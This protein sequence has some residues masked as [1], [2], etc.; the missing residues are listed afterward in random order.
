[1]ITNFAGK[2][3]TNWY[4]VN[5]YIYLDR[6]DIAHVSHSLIYILSVYSACNFTKTGQI[7]IILM[8]P[9]LCSTH[10]YLYA[11]WLTS[12]SIPQRFF[13][14]AIAWPE[15]VFTFNTGPPCSS[16]Q[17][18]KIKQSFTLQ[19]IGNNIL[20]WCNYMIIFGRVLKPFIRRDTESKPLKLRLLQEILEH[21]RK[22]E[23]SFKAPSVA[24]IDYCY[25]RPQHIPSINALCREFFWPGIDC[26]CS[27]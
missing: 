24:P 15:W 9:E 23:P 27:V 4:L 19:N 7:S 11:R 20:Q 5:Y 10:Q 21:H 13:H 14:N 25:V 22:V 1:M 8:I 16:R 26:K 3:P 12:W 17:W 18:F 2:P 6:I